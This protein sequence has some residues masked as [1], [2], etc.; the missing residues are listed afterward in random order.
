VVEAK[1]GG[2]SIDNNLFNASPEVADI[3]FHANPSIDDHIGL[4]SLTNSARVLTA[5]RGSGLIEDEELIVDGTV[6]TKFER[7]RRWTP[8]KCVAEDQSVAI[9]SDAVLYG[10]FEVVLATWLGD[11][12]NTP[13]RPD[14]APQPPDRIRYVDHDVTWRRNPLLASGP[15]VVEAPFGPRTLSAT[16]YCVS[17]SDPEL[18]VGEPF[19]IDYQANKFTFRTPAYTTPAATAALIFDAE[20]R[21]C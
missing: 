14:D 3:A 15:G 19:V 13:C 18:K 16:D 4:N 20:G 8:L 11:P 9:D 10:A 12:A 2:I 6:I 7:A 21:G 5:N 17:V 1:S